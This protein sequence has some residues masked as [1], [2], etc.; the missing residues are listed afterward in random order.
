MPVIIKNQEVISDTYTFYSSYTSGDV[1]AERSIIPID[2]FLANPTQFEQ[3]SGS[4]GV[5]LDSHHEPEVLSPYIHQLAVI[6]INFPSFTDGRGYSIARI[7]RE[8]LGYQGELRAVGDIL[9]D[10]LFYLK[11]CGFD[12]FKLHAEKDPEEALRGLNAF[13]VSYQGANDHP[14]P[15]FRRRLH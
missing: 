11:R 3:H 10:Q 12:A 9:H 14:Q 2:D 1:L 7:L 13:S 4:V 6:A 8:R 15:L 5:W